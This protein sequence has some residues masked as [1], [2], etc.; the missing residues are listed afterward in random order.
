MRR[1]LTGVRRRHR[2]VRGDG[3]RGTTLL[4]MVVGMT[5]MTIF[6]GIFTGAILMLYRSSNKAEAID[7]STAQLNQAFL[8]LDKAVRYA[9]AIS[10][11]GTST[12]GGTGDWYVELRT[13]NTGSEV[14][15]Q[16]RTDVATGQLQRRTWTVTNS[17]ASGVTPWVQL[18]SGLGNAGAAAGSASQPFVLQPANATVNYQQLTFTL[19]G[20]SGAGPS[21]TSSRSS[22]LFTA[23]NSTSPPPSGVCQFTGWRP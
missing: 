8:T 14:C 6:M 10:V 17:V 13:T 1:L 20:Q 16:L 2:L 9:A 15:T 22:Y 12:T 4:E 7:L 19:V 21:Q 18:A 23:L 3:E 11:P 5:I